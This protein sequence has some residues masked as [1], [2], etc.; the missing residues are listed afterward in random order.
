MVRVTNSCCIGQV[1]FGRQQSQ[2]ECSLTYKRLT[3]FPFLCGFWFLSTGVGT[4]NGNS[5]APGMLEVCWLSFGSYSRE[6]LVDWLLQ[7]ELFYLLGL[8]LIYFHQWQWLGAWKTVIILDP[9]LGQLYLLTGLEF[10]FHRGPPRALA[11]NRTLSWARPPLSAQGCFLLALFS[12][13]QSF[14]HNLQG[15]GIS[16]PF[17]VIVIYQ[18]PRTVFSHG[19]A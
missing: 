2:L 8:M 12:T 11:G 14:P 16:L 3:G 7:H 17:L 19:S 6:S 13:L 5:R 10:T 1:R 9:S 18:H 4:E 15:F